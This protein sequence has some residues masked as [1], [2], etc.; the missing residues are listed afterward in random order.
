MNE[1]IIDQTFEGNSYVQKALSLNDYE[2]CVFKNCDFSGSSLRQIGFIRCE[3]IDCNLST[4]HI[5][6]TQL[7]EC[8]FFE[9]KL[10]GLQFEN[11]D[12]FG[13][14]VQFDHTQLDD[15][16]FY[17]C[18]LRNSGFSESNLVHVDFT[19]AN[20]EGI[21]LDFCNL[22]RS[23]FEDTNLKSANLY[24]ATN[25]QIDPNRN[26]IKKAVFSKEGLSGLLE[27]HQLI[28]KP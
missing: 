7:Q 6:G 15:S 11:C 12:S 13:F 25:Y 10:L 16:S 24:S 19:E 4:A 23:I 1:L 14:S 5:V 9:S 28:I 21:D 27:K 20:L 8:L 3:F 2:N 18:D 17:Q 22:S 26:Q